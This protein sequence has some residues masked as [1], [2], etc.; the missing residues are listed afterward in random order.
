MDLVVTPLPVRT[1]SNVSVVYSVV[2]LSDGVSLLSLARAVELPVAEV[3]DC[4]SELLQLGFVRERQ[5]FWNP[6]FYPG[7]RFVV[8]VTP[9]EVR[10]ARS[11][12]CYSVENVDHLCASVKGSYS[13]AFLFFDVASEFARAIA[14]NL[15]LPL[16][17]D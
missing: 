4:L 9:S 1:R 3:W 2:V 13:L 5:G 10:L 11:P 15:Q 12:V 8:S 17:L 16:V 6:R 7:D 14:S